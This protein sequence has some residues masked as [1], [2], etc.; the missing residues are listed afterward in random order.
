MLLGNNFYEVLKCK[1]IVCI[2]YCRTK[3]VKTDGTEYKVDTGVI[4]DV[5]EDDLPV[6]GCIRHIYVIN[7]TKVIFDVTKY[8]TTFEPHFRAYLLSEAEE[9]TS[10][11]YIYQTEL[12][13]RSP[14]H[15]RKSQVFGTNK[16]IILPHA[17]FAL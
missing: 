13:L 7:N 11:T 2:L 1:Y 4:L 15:V 9:S 16:Y 17:V 10:A 8:T 3:W 6:V 12:F 14:V 5:D